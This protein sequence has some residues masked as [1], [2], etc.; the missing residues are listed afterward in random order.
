MLIPIAEW[1]QDRHLTGRGHSSY[2]SAPPAP[3]TDGP[4]GWGA[5][6]AGVM[7]GSS[8]KHGVSALTCRAEQPETLPTPTTWIS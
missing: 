6:L 4:L 1:D 8:T 7:R 2:C 5:E 3:A